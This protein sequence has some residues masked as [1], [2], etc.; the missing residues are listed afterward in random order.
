M[1]TYKN[2]RVD[3][4]KVKS[5]KPKVEMKNKI[6]FIKQ[7]LSCSVPLLV[8]NNSNCNLEINGGL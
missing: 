5:L 4:E 8:F 1:K 6:N 3:F 7:E 2:I